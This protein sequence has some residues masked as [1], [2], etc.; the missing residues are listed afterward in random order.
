SGGPDDDNG[1]APYVAELARQLTQAM[2]EGDAYTA[3]LRVYTTIDTRD[4]MAA[5]EA[6][7]KG[8]IDYD[9]KHGYRGPESYVRLPADPEGTRAAIEAAVEEAGRIN[10][11]HPA[12]VTAASEKSVTVSRGDGSPPIEITGKGLAFVKRALGAK[13]PA[14]TRLQP[15][16]LVRIV[17]ER[18]GWRISQLPQ[19]QAAFVAVNTADGSV[20][21]LVGGYD[22]ERNKF[23]RVTQAW[24]Q[25]GSSFKPF[26]YS[27]ALEKGFM[28]STIVNDAPFSIDP[29]LTGGDL[30]EPKNYDGK[31]EGPMTMAEG[32]ARSKNMVSIRILQQ[33]GPDY[34]QDYVSRFGF[35]A[36]R[37]PA[38]L[39]MA[40]GA[41][42]VTPWQMAGGFSTFANGGYRVEPYI[43]SKITNSA[44]EVLAAARPRQAG[45]PH[46]RT[47]DPRNAFIMDSMLR[48]VVRY[49]TATRARTALKRNDLAGKTGTTND[50]H[51]AWFAGYQHDIA[52]VAWVGFDQPRK[53]GNRETGGGLALPI[54]VDYMR[55]ALTDKPQVDPEPPG[56]IVQIGA[57][58][59]YS[60]T[61]PGQGIATVGLMEGGVASG[62]NADQIRDQ[63]F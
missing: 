31:F 49:G 17:E 39:T 16:A 60:E 10:E 30:W 63:L 44:G 42:A 19:V 28:V 7:R 46:N 55:T 32:L 51:D 34:A 8:V 6:L 53:L 24:R 29:A 5:R 47:I 33:I 2:F 20:R 27:A 52:A 18:D 22:F 12:V 37:H 35:E 54:W 48:D 56:G 1:L 26:I 9:T 43:V 58:W 15:G 14:A 25:P 3:G 41:G 21:A 45:D 62:E 50:S 13:A 23:N 57:D 4:Q 38:Y 61:R 40:L 36:T 59:Y 11:F